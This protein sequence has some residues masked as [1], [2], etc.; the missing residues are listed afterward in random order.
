MECIPSS[1][2]QG[3]NP[4]SEDIF[5]SLSS[6]LVDVQKVPRFAYSILTDTCSPENSIESWENFLFINADE[7]SPNETDWEE[8][9]EEF[10]M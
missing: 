9:H 1:W 4:G 2:L 10:Q 5:E 3:S 7:D 6:H 8:I